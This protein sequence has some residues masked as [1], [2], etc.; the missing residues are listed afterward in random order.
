MSYVAEYPHP[1]AIGRESERVVLRVT[2]AF[3]QYFFFSLLGLFLF[4]FP[5][6]APAQVSANLGGVVTDASGA[7]VSGAKVT[8]KNVDTGESRSTATDQAGRYR[9]SQL[10]LG[11]Y[12]VQ[13]MKDGF[14]RA[15]R[16]GIRLAVGQDATAD[17]SL[18]IGRVSE[19][20]RVTGDA[21]VVNLTT[22][23]ISGL[24][25]E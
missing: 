12:E 24:V 14:A 19:E 9:L 20:V 23:N 4:S 5:A 11:S 1:H 17:L 25:G 13:A 2:P 8:A 6:V 15:V 3:K 18:R 21:P 7:T 22:Q 16:S 10:P